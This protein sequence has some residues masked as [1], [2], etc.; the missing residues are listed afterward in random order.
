MQPRKI[1]VVER[2]RGEWKTMFF[3]AKKNTKQL[4]LAAASSVAIEVALAIPNSAFAGACIPN[5][6]STIAA[7]CTA[8][9]ITSNTSAIT[10]SASITQ[11]GFHVLSG[12]TLGGLSNSSIG[13]IYGNTGGILN[14]G[15]IGTITNNGSIHGAAGGDGI[16]NTGT[17]SGITNTS[18]GSIYGNTGAI[19]NSGT[20]ATLTNNGNLSSTAPTYGVISNSGSIGTLTNSGTIT[21]PTAGAIRNAGFIATLINSGNIISPSGVAVFDIYGTIQT[22]N[23]TGTISGN[24]GIIDYNSLGLTITPGSIGFIN[25]IGTIIGKATTGYAIYSDNSIGTLT[26]SGLI[27]GNIQLSNPITINGG[28]GGTFGT[29]TGYPSGSSGTITSSA[30]IGFASGSLILNDDINV[31]SNTVSNSGAAIQFNTI[32]TITGT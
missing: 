26:N 18:I 8:Y 14:A 11:Y 30:N 12:V 13:S 6:S 29:F 19:G 1:H 3:S 28:S 4:L 21:S 24:S 31:G 32:H 2:M 7:N 16:N 15:T 22:I 10:N 17:I 23:N 25:N 27:S 5:G 20:I 9:T